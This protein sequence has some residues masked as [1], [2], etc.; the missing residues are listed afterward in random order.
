MHLI[1]PVRTRANRSV[2]FDRQLTPRDG[3]NS[4]ASRT[5][6]AYSAELKVAWQTAD[7]S[8]LALESKTVRLA[9]ISVRSSDDDHIKRRRDN[10]PMSAI[11]NRVESTHAIDSGLCDVCFH[12]HYSVL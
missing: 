7:P 3:L 11:G 10:G 8:S 12:V 1:M 6:L 9:R 5:L 2:G 4:T